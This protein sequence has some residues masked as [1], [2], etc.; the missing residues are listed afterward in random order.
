LE[1]R[2][3]IEIGVSILFGLKV[4]AN[5]AI[6][7]MAEVLM[8]NSFVISSVWCEVAFLRG[9][10]GHFQSRREVSTNECIYP[11]REKRREVRVLSLAP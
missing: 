3:D 10:V 5:A 9:Q 4:W 1:L 7:L 8:D 6:F 11:F 2:V